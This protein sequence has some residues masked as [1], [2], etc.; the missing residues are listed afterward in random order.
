MPAPF[1]LARP[2]APPSRPSPIVKISPANSLTTLIRQDGSFS[3][4]L[5]GNLLT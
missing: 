4:A 1:A 3:A 2:P 5:P